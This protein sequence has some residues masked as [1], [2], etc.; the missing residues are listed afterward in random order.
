VREQFFKAF[1]RSGLAAIVLWLA[2]GCG[3]RQQADLVIANTSEPE[4][5]DPALITAQADGRIASALYEGLLARDPR[6]NLVPGVAER[7]EVSDDGLTYRFYLRAN[8]RWSDGRRVVARDFVESWRRALLPAT[9][10]KY[11]DLTLYHIEGAEDFHRGVTTDFGTVAVRAVSDEVLEL[12]LRQRT[13]YFLDL[14]AFVTTFPVRVDRIGEDEG[15][16]WTRPARLVSNGA[17]VLESWHINNRVRLRANPHY[18]NR[19]NVGMAVVDVVPLPQATTALNFYLSGLVD[20][21]PDKAQV[22]TAL[23]E[24]L[25]RRRD[26]HS[27]PILA[28]YFFRIN[29]TR[30]PFDNALVR[31]ALAL[32]LDRDFIVR[33]ITRAGEPP[34]GALVPPGLRGYEPPRGLLFDPQAA[35]RLLAE[36]GYPQGRGFPV[37]ELLYNPTEIN[38]AVAE[39]VQSMWSRELGLTVELRRQ[40]FRT[41]LN[42][43]SSL[44]YSVARS[45]WIGDYADP[46]TFL[47]CF[48]TGSGNNRTGY[49]STEYDGLLASAAAEPDSERRMQ[50]L[51]QAEQILVERDVP[52]IPVFHFVTVKL[53]DP[54]K[55]SG[56]AMNLLDDFPIQSIKKLKHRRPE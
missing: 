17:Y 6:G 35:R 56:V 33:Q 52:V 45:S 32:A 37:L 31:R 24:D 29:V 22:P 20:V 7:W 15:A 28:T 30:A 40:E 14:C 46:T 27:A 12:R 44:S 43:M 19:A 34:T 42:T 51:R 13:P 4:T 48:V 18:W 1:G 26:F 3:E 5:L 25:R 38:D 16:N 10:S 39:A 23:L 55:L 54:E 50:L 11:V 53:F 36:A 49:S 47:G 21:L 41:Y 8:A 2:A 9:G